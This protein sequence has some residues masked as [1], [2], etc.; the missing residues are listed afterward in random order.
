MIRQ[1]FQYFLNRLNN[2]I[3]V[4]SDYLSENINT[5]GKLISYYI[6]TGALPN[7]NADIYY[8][9][10]N[11]YGGN[12]ASVKFGKMTKDGQVITTDTYA[13][14]TGGSK[15]TDVFSISY[16]NGD[17]RIT[18]LVDLQY[19]SDISMSNPSTLKANEYIAWG[20]IYQHNKALYFKEL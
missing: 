10:T 3:N 11:T 13:Y 8:C 20:G 2:S 12:D 5:L 18:A 14:N 6:E 7:I 17:F 4:N 16:P 19:S 1:S 15:G 9:M